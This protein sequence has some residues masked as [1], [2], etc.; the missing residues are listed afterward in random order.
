MSDYL[1]NL[2]ARSREQFPTIRPRLTSL[3]EPVD[4]FGVFLPEPQPVANRFESKISGA[5]V[6]G[7]ELGI[8]SPGTP[9]PEP[10]NLPRA[11]IESRI[12][13]GSPTTVV[14]RTRL[15]EKDHQ[16]VFP[17]RQIGAAE[18]GQTLSPS[19]R[20]PSIVAPKASEMP[21][22]ASPMRQIQ[23]PIESPAKAEALI[24]KI[25]I[26]TVSPP[27][28]DRAVE[29][30][31]AQFPVPPEP[32]ESTQLKEPVK[33]NVPRRLGDERVEDGPHVEAHAVRRDEMRR[34]PP[35]L[36]P[37]VRLEANS[38]PGERERSSIIAGTI[39]PS[40]ASRRRPT[41]RASSVP[42]APRVRSSE[43]PAEEAI[44]PESVEP[45]INVTIG[46]VEI[47]AVSDPASQPKAGGTKTPSTLMGLDDYLRRRAQGGG[48]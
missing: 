3:F 48:R 14:S 18:E 35:V 28:K 46:R 9:A 27:V 5:P 4:G 47:R 6:A 41:V 29:P 26:R 7:D 20:D 30:V 44:R 39:S 13:D 43:R 42:V 12:E 1:T 22:V 32:L 21:S 17:V 10:L 40:P 38:F 19:E 15:L 25:E 36:V 37:R 24:P 23:P 16:T 2:A 8:P 31:S 45:V 34:D 11:E 33:S